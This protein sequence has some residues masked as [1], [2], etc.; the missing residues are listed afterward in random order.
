[1]MSSNHKWYVVN[2]ASGFEKQAQS[3]LKQRITQSGMDD[4]FGET[5]IPT[6]EVVEMSEG[7]QRRSKR[8]FFSGYILIEMELDDETWHL[9]KNTPHILGF[10]GGSSKEPLPMKDSEIDAIVQRVRDSSN[11]P[12]PKILFDIGETVRVCEGP[13]NDFT[14][15]VEEVDYEKNHMKVL[16]QILGRTTPV[17]LEFSQV[18]KT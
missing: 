7:K 14:G 6:E 16:V 18:E 2:T 8:K 5:L 4:K 3:S 15:M 10:V 12:Q 9:V 13:F 11:K 1:M 17:D